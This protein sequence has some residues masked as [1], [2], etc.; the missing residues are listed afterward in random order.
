M[1]FTWDVTFGQIVVGVP[2]LVILGILVRLDRLIQNFRI[3]HEYLMNDWASRQNPKIN[4][5][6]LPTRTK[7]KF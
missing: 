3:E 5:K 6:D 7:I 4:V 1:H 2:V